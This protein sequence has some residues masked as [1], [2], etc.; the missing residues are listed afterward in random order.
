M[1]NFWGDLFLRGVA[2]CLLTALTLV[3]LRRAAAAYRHLMCVLALCGLLALPSAQRLLPPLLLLTPPP[4]PTP[5]RLTVPTEEV[6]RL[7]TANSKSDQP[8]LSE[9]PRKQAARTPKQTAQTNSATPLPPDN[10][11]TAHR[12]VAVNPAPHQK[13]SGSATVVLSRSGGWGPPLS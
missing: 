6:S 12:A 8:S 5:E 1:Q 4:A 7:S 2:L 3:L 10:F 11:P 13:R 9:M